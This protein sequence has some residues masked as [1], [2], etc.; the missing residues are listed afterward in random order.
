MERR[1]HRRYQMWFPVQVE[2]G[3]LKDLKAVDHNIG[4]GGMLIA[5]SAELEVGQEVRITFRVPPDNTEERS[6][7]GRIL[8]VE[9]NP[10]DTEG[11]WPYRVAIAF[12]ELAPDLTPLLDRAVLHMVDS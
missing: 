10:Y 4:P 8:R 3:D 1:K 11:T 12:F 5:L 7:A 6:V 9:K 2:C